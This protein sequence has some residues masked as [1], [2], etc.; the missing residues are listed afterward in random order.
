[1]T[2]VVASNSSLNGRSIANL[3]VSGWDVSDDHVRV[4]CQ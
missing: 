2:T 4:G 1:M 3:E